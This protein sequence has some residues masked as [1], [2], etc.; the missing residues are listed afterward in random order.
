M[1]VGD[2]ITIGLTIL[3]ALAMLA[4]GPRIVGGRVQGIEIT[5]SGRAIGQFSL[6]SDRMIEASG[7]LG[8]TQ[9][10]IKDGKAAIRSSPCS[11]KYCVHMG[12]IGPSGGILVC[13]PNE[14]VVSSVR[15]RD[16]GL[17]AVSR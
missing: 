7:T 9:V 15:P 3:L 13:V 12:E 10:R 8:V 14:I 2:F 17:D 6:E 4:L 11:N 1:V 16:D 5:S